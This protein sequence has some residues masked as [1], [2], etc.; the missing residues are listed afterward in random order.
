MNKHT[1]KFDSERSML[2]LLLAKLQKI[3]ADAY[4]GHDMNFEMLLFHL[5]SHKV[6]NWSRIGRLKRSTHM[7]KVSIAN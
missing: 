5:V 3:D 1:F 2:G 4:V 6:A 7:Q